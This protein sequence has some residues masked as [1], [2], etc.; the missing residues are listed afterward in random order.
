MSSL[1]EALWNYF[2]DR[3]V[4]FERCAV[5]LFRLSAPAVENADVTRPSRDG[6]RD[7]VGQYAIGPKADPVRLSFA[8]EAKCY[9]P[10]NAV[11]V[12]E[13]ARL[14]SRIKHREF[15]VLVTTSYVHD[16]A[17]KEVREDEHP[18]VILSGADLVAILKQAGLGT[19]TA[20]RL[21]LAQAHPR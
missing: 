6:G 8:L 18:I 1:L 15:G 16:Q 3:P 14:V 5:E 2:K 7:A 10:G 11:G 21:W 19:P 4:D 12:R 17:Y 9:Q 20:V 13:V